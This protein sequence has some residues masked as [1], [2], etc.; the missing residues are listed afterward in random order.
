M[1]EKEIES[2]G[3]DD[4]FSE[5]E[6]PSLTTGVIC[7]ALAHPHIDLSDEREWEPV[8]QGMKLRHAMVIAQTPLTTPSISNRWSVLTKVQSEKYCVKD[9]VVIRNEKDLDNFFRRIL[10]LP[11]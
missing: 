11:L 9:K 3:D 4:N 6:I 8:K 2:N 1:N 10:P 5:S 7:A